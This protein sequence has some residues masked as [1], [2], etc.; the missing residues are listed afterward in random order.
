MI[1]LHVHSTASD[2]S[3][4]PAEI[5]RLASAMRLK[6]V[7]LTDH[8]TV[9]GLEEF[10]NT[11]PE[12][13]GVELIPGIELAAMEEQ[14]AR[15]NCHIVGLFL[16]EISDRMRRLLE[17][18]MRWRDERN[19]RMVAKIND[20]G[21]PLTL[22]DVKRCAGGDVI[23]RPHIALAMI[24]K[25]YVSSLPSAFE[26]FLASGKPGYDGRKLPG[27]S[28]AIAAIHSCGGIAIWAHP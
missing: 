1:D 16:N 19:Q 6:A 11:A 28:E 24:E 18:V 12:F 27:C 14:E 26:R 25:G 21:M 22:D 5:V 7:A 8:D 3:H 4:S 2:G 9:A 23:G 10:M 20:L 15:Q 17:D 13:P